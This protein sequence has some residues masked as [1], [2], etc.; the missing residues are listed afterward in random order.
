[1]EQVKVFCGSDRLAKKGCGDEV[2]SADFLT[3][4]IN[5]WLRANPDIDIVE[6]KM[7]TT[8][9]ALSRYGVH[10]FYIT[11]TIFYRDRSST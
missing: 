3:E 2:N 5:T 8:S 4:E 1:M 7:D 11:V 6:R 9:I 10:Y